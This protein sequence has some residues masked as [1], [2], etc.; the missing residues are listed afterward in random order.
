MRWQSERLNEGATV[1]GKIM[2]SDNAG[3]RLR[4]YSIFMRGLFLITTEHK[5]IND[6]I[7]QVLQYA[8]PGVRCSVYNDTLRYT[9]SIGH[10]LSVCAAFLYFSSL[11]FQMDTNEN[12]IGKKAMC[13]WANDF[14]SPF[15][16]N[17][18]KYLFHSSNSK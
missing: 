7:S 2:V 17:Q 6:W 9:N 18:F 4:R 16:S 13:L 3:I 12:F 15:L 8:A 14:Y 5:L 1:C 11:K 10:K